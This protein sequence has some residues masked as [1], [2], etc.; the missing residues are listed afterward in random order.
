MI[1]QVPDVR[2]GHSAQTYQDKIIYYGGWNGYT[3][4]DDVI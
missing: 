4:L 2:M 3:V 1:G